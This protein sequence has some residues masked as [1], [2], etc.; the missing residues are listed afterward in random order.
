MV[1]TTCRLHARV[2]VLGHV[3]VPFFERM[4]PNFV[5]V[6]FGYTAAAFCLGHQLC[7]V[8][9]LCIV[10]LLRLVH[11][12]LLLDHLLVLLLLLYMMDL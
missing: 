7:L 11:L 2:H 8:H 1:G 6:V 4:C 3:H 10:H 9:L 12:L 5:L